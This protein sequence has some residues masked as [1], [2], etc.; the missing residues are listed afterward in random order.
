ML[1]FE[2]IFVLPWRS[3]NW[4]LLHPSSHLQSFVSNARYLTCCFSR[5][6]SDFCLLD[7]CT[8]K[9]LELPGMYLTTSYYLPYLACRQFSSKE[10]VSTP[11]LIFCM[12]YCYWRILVVHVSLSVQ[13]TPCFCFILLVFVFDIL[14]STLGV[15]RSITL[16]LV[17]SLTVQV[18][19]WVLCIHL[20]LTFHIWMYILA[21]IFIRR[22]I[23]CSHPS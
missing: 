18:L 10:F 13:D 12:L 3:H 1:C 9:M 5:S 23:S 11:C 15:W 8:I 14:I 21:N 2:L 16:P 6:L 20:M 22:L 4:I 7:L 19:T 17:S